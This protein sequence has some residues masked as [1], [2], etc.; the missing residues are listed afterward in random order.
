MIVFA[1]IM[2]HPPESIP[3]IGSYA[4][5]KRAQKTIN[6]FG[7]L[8]SDFEDAKIDT[9][10]VISPHAEMES[11]VFAIN[12]SP[13]LTGN[14][15]EF[16]L[17][18]PQSY[19]NNLEIAD[20]LAY[21]SVMNEIPAHLHPYFLDHG[22]LV[23]LY[24]LTKSVKPL[25]VHLSFS[26][27]SYEYHYS[28]GEVLHNILEESSKNFAIVA[29]GDLSHKLTHDSPAGF[30][31]RAREFD[32]L[33]LFNMGENNVKGLMDL[34]EDKEFDR[35]AAECGLRSFVVM[36]GALKGTSFKFD[37][38]SYE[39]PFGIGYLTARLL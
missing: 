23:P 11:Y 32:R 7:R 26:L 17:D 5:Q 30:F 22:A 9:V 33:A 35:E 21:A 6:A 1:A 29:S 37:L 15:T 36:Y 16:G 25:V 34:G 4:D 14:F 28:Y 8:R 24:H 31:P 27:M 12:S 10:I 3:G 19:S 2:P 18:M 20:S 38:L 39:S 13:E